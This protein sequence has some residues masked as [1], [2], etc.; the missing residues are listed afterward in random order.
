[1]ECAVAAFG[2]KRHPNPV[3]PSGDVPQRMRLDCSGKRMFDIPLRS[4]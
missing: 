4:Q 2:S 1:M 3:L